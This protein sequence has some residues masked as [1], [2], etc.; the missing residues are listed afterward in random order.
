[1]KCIIDLEKI[2]IYQRRKLNSLLYEWI[3]KDA[4]SML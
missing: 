3:P 4:V 1:M 2:N